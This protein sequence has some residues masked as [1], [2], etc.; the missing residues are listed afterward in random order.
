MEDADGTMTG[1]IKMV[2]G[3]VQGTHAHCL[4]GKKSKESWKQFE[5]EIE[6]EIAK[7]EVI[8]QI[9]NLRSMLWK[10]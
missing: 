4:Q 8:D 9:Q 5:K 3:K 7:E 1:V 6:F 2:D 10:G